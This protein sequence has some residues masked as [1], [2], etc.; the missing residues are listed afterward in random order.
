MGKEKGGHSSNG[1]HPEGEKKRNRVNS[2]EMGT[3]PTRALTKGL[4]ER[5][6]SRATKMGNKDGW[7]GDR[8]FKV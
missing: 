8:T 7:G 3:T 6:L 1:A 5:K 4:T 2:R